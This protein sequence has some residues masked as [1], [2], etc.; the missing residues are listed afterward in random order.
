ML[1]CGFRLGCGLRLGLV[2]GKRSVNL[3]RALGSLTESQRLAVYEPAQ[4]V[5]VLAGAGS[6]KTRVLTLRVARRIRDGE[7]EADH[8]VVCTFTRKA[9]ADLRARLRAF[10]VPTVT[11]GIATRTVRPAPA[12]AAGMPTPA[13]RTTPDPGRSTSS[14]PMLGSSGESGSIDDGVD[15]DAGASAGP[16][17]RAGT[18]HQLALALLRR[19]AADAHQRPPQLAG[20]R[21]RLLTTLLGDQAVASVADTEI[22]W[23]KA[24]CLSPDQY[25]V[26]AFDAG[27]S[28]GGLGGSGGRSGGSGGTGPPGPSVEAIEVMADHYRTYEETLRRRGLLDLDD[29]LLRAHDLIEADSGFAD[30]VRWRYRHLSVDEFQDVNPAQYRLVR[31]ILGD[32]RDL[33]VVGD[34]NQAIYG[35]NGADPTLLLRLPQLIPG[36]AVHHLDDNHR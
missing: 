25:A 1:G 36:I 18:L 19:Q 35:W 12:Q 17:V 26:L 27:R 30:A 4:A 10:G 24:R 29:V 8:T 7:A 28:P 33:F 15:L 5:C 14:A 32:R 16:G 2:S 22:T 11:P 20:N 6:G 31:T 34:P 13:A 21:F 3:D 23:A 9:A